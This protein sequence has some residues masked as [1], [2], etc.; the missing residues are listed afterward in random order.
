MSPA[1]LRANRDTFTEVDKIVQSNAGKEMYLDPALARTAVYR[2]F[3]YV[4]N[5]NREAYAEYINGRRNGTIK[6]SPLV[7]WLVAET[8]QGP[9]RV[10]PDAIMERADIVICTAR[11]PKQG[12]HQLVRSL[13]ILS[14][15]WSGSLAVR[16]YANAGK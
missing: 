9:E 16:M 11:C 4:D 5:G 1:G 10:H 3:K 12:T 2:H 13:G 7:S 6:L 15:G 14:V 8:P